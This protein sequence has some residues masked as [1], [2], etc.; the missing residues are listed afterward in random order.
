[1]ENIQGLFALENKILGKGS[2][3]TVFLGTDLSKER[4]VAL[5]QIPKKIMRDPSLI[6]LL[7]N[8]ILI[9]SGIKHENLVNIL[10]IAEINTEKYIVYEFCNGGDLRRYLRFFGRFDEN[11]V[12]SCMK[13]ILSG[14]NALHSKGIIHHDLKPEN[15]LVELFPSNDKVKVNLEEKMSY[16]KII[17][18][19]LQVTDKNNMNYNIDRTYRDFVYKSLLKSRIKVSDFG[20]SKFK[21]DNNERSLNGSPVYMDPNLFIPNVPINVIESEK[22]D[23]WALG[24]FAFELFFGYFPFNPPIQNLGTLI[25][26]L[27]KG[28]YVIDLQRCGRISKQFL[29]FLNM[30]LQRIQGIRPSATELLFSEFI[31]RDTNKFDYIDINNYRYFK[32]PNQNYISYKGKIIMTIDDQRAFNKIYE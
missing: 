12:Q 28:I 6:Q 21:G 11:L 22:V 3:G 30:C 17:D 23:I 24:V 14:L 20:L 2:F 19:I 18:E 4:S 9:S 13:Q 25:N 31:T 10:D 16:E 29:S 27:Q 5:K 26:I 32:Y 1:M 7:S 8:E 15:V